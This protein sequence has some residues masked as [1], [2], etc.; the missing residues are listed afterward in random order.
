MLG[1]RFLTDH[2]SGDQYFRVTQRGENLL[3]AR[4]QFELFENFEAEQAQ[5]FAAAKRVL[6]GV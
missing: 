3:R 4:E 6:A 1:V 5:M 2:L